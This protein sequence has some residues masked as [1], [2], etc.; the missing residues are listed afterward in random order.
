[1]TLGSLGFLALENETEL[2]V[3]VCYFIPGSKATLGEL[4][5]FTVSISYPNHLEPIRDL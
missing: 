5:D 4:V 3:N 2:V 1:M